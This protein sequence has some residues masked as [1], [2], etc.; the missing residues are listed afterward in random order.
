MLDLVTAALLSILTGQSAAGATAEPWTEP[1]TAEAFLRTAEVVALESFDSKGITRPRK[2]TLSDGE[3]S[4][5][6]VFKVVDTHMPKTRAADGRMLFNL[7]DSYRHEIAAYEL[8]KLLGLGL[9]PATVERRIGREIGS[10][11]LWVEGAMTEWQRKKVDRLTPPDME[12]WNNQVSTLKIFFQLIWD[13]DYNNISNVIVDREWK[14]WK[15]DSSR[16]FLASG[17]LRRSESLTRF[18]R[19]LLT[20]L[21]DLGRP[22]L[23]DALGP[24]LSRKQIATLWQ[25]RQDILDLAARRV[26]EYGEA[27]V[28]YD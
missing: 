8:D 24:W 20:A 22:Q 28:L 17:K 26:A 14:I 1:G 15:I 5:N 16:A 7:K 21:A 25:R 9:V 18:P 4:A 12:V 27:T 23:E 2:A 10:L 6:A 19:S 3:R 13:T 11:Q